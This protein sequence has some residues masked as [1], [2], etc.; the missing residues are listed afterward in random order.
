VPHL[1]S[2][3]DAGPSAAAPAAAGAEATPAEQLVAVRPDVLG[4]AEHALGNLFQRVYHVTRLAR[5]GLGGHAD[6]L[7]E[8]LESIERLL[9]LVFDYVSPVEVDL[10]PIGAAKVLESLASQVRSHRGAAGVS[11]GECPALR[12]VGDPRVLGRSFQLL[13]SALGRDWERAAQVALEVAHDAEGERVCFMVHAG[14]GEAGPAAAD[15]NLA[16]AVAGRLI[17]L[18]GGYL[19]TAAAG[20][21]FA[22]SITLPIS[23]ESHGAV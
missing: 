8:A 14:V 5:E 20:G 7:T 9:E 2:N 22:C 17:D 18:L 19:Q 21:A 23:T 16:F 10:R 12:V 11:L 3:V 13:G 1:S 4:D 6:R 15:A